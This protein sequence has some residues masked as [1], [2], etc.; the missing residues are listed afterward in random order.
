MTVLHATEPPTRLPLGG[1]AGR[2]GLRVADVD[3]ALYDDRTLVKQLAMRRTLFVFPRDLLPAAW[4]APAARVAGQERRRIA[5]DVAAGGHRR[6]RR[7]PGSTRRAPRSLDGAGR[8][9]DGLSAR[10]S[11]RA[12]PDVDGTVGLAGHEVGRRGADRPA[13]ARAGSGAEGDVV[14]GRNAGH[15]RISRPAWTPMD[16]LARGGARAAAGGRGLRRAGPPVAADLRPG[17]EADLVW[18]LGATKGAVRRALA[19]LGAVAGRA[20]TAAAPAGCCPTTTRGRPG[21]AVGGAAAGARPDHDG[22]EAT[23]TFYLDPGHTPYLFDSNGNGGTT[24]WWNGRVVGCWVQDDDGWCAW[25]CAGRCRADAT[26]ALATEAE[27]LTAWL[28]GVRISQ[29]LHLPPDEVRAAAL[30]RDR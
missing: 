24:A 18:W 1:R 29:R 6:R 3:R 8:E 22:L 20:S 9:P 25:C 15:W 11:G 30:T 28:D 10:R 13:G 2:R 21:R 12:V 17:T 4:G 26:A 14:R 7:R 19:D 23:A 5:K 27:R 16:G